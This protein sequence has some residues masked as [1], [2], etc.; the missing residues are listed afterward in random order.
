MEKT[1][2]SKAGISHVKTAVLVLVFCM[3][4]SAV[5][6]YAGMMTVIQTSRDTT[7]RVLDSFVTHNSTLIYD[8]L[9]NGHDFTTNLDTDFYKNLLSG[10]F[11][12]DFY[13]NSIYALDEDGQIVYYMT[14][15]NVTY[16][17]T[18]TLKLKASYIV[19]IPVR[20]A[21]E[22][23]TYLNV[24]ITVHSYYNLK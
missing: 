1:F 13:G 11:S 6:T 23:V 10:E 19:G 5:L 15:P 18:N 17:Y 20:F 24:P 12:L 2:A 22:I 8:S 3:I 4:L 7:T 21:G 14:N 16:D 9:K